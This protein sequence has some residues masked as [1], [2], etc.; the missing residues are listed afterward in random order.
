MQMSETQINYTQATRIPQVQR[1]ICSY[2]NLR[3]EH[4]GWLTRKH[5][6]CATIVSPFSR[7][8]NGRRDRGQSVDPG[9]REAFRVRKRIATEN[10]GYFLRPTTGKSEV[11]RN[12]GKCIV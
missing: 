11:Y 8:G 3:A 4:P 9:T 6:L 12:S 5:A 7:A 1:A 2:G 10:S